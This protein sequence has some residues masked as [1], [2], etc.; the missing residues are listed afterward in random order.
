MRDFIG[1]VFSA[2]LI[3]VSL[4]VGAEQA[5]NLNC[6]DASQACSEASENALL[7]GATGISRSV[8]PVESPM[9]NVG[10]G[11]VGANSTGVNFPQSDR[12]AGMNDTGRNQAQSPEKN[13]IAICLPPRL[14]IETLLMIFILSG[15]LA[16]FLVKGF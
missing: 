14:R 5:S 7:P 6:S 4:P 2:F 11:A 9:R 12:R 8:N 15:A 1:A 16:Y 10:G 3:F 13:T